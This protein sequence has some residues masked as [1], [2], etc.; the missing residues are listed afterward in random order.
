MA[1]LVLRTN[2]LKASS[3]SAV[4]A[5]T[6]PLLVAIEPSPA[7]SW[8]GQQPCWMKAALPLSASAASAFVCQAATAASARATGSKAVR[9]QYI[10]TSSAWLREHID[11]RRLA[12]FHHGD[13]FLDRRPKIRR[14]GDRPLR[15]PSHRL[16]E[17]VIGN[18]GIHDAGAD[19]R[20]IVADIGDAVT[21]VGEL[22]H[23]HDLLVITAVVVHHGEQRNLVPRRRP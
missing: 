10:V 2:D 9:R 15:P 5:M 3:G 13:R 7:K 20:Q 23:V 21:E 22:L 16:R 4:R 11:Q 12:G 19:R 18:V 6:L 1:P 17:L 8:H 14:I